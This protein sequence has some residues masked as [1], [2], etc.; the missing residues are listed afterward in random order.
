MKPSDSLCNAS[1]SPGWTEEEIKVL[2]L[3]IMKFG[4]GNWTQLLEGG[5]L[6]GKSISQ[7][8]NQARRMLGQ[9]SS[10]EFAGLHIDVLRIGEV[11]RPKEGLRKCGVLIHTGPKLTRQETLQKIEQNR[12]L[13]ELPPEEYESIQLDDLKIKEDRLLGQMRKLRGLRKQL[14]EVESQLGQFTSDDL[15]SLPIV[16]AVETK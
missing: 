12:K 4:L 16:L 1:I 10:A 7:L 3:A 14:A 8:N 11:N 13:Y 2:R 15:N 9:Q 5:Y 6:P